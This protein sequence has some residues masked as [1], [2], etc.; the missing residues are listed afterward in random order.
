VS[1]GTL[2]DHAEDL[3]AFRDV[4]DT[5][6]LGIVH[7][8]HPFIAPMRAAKHGTLVGIASVAGFRGLP[9]PAAYSASKSATIT[10]LESLRVELRGSGVSVVTIAPGYVATP[11]TE[12]NPY[13]MPFLMRPE[14]RRGVDGARDR[15]PQ[16]LPRDAVADG[17]RSA[18]C[19][20]CCR[21][22]LRRRVREGAAQAAPPVNAATDWAG[23][24][25]ARAGADA[26]IASLVPSLTELL[27]A[28][29]L[30]DR[31]VARTGFCV[32]PHDAVRR[33]RKVGGTKD[34][35]LE[36]LREARPTHLIVNVDENRREAVDA[37][38][39]FVPDVIVTHP[40]APDDNRRLYALFG[41]IFDRE[42]HAA[43][44]A[45]RLDAALASLDR[46]VAARARER[47]LYL[48]WREPWMTVSRD[49]YVAATLR[50]R[51]ARHAARA[52]V[53]PLP[54]DRRRRS[55]VARRRS[56]PA[57]D[58]AVRVPRARPRVARARDRK[59]VDLVDGEWTSWYGVA[60]DRRARGARAL[61][62]A[63]G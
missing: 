11:M 54:G 32:H 41:A 30:G 17:A 19:C 46:A 20:A 6:V 49:T 60:R 50:T 62:Q 52:R 61:P 7:T 8:F 10:L 2:A 39:A 59:R 12:R 47:V 24:A 14:P 13:R 55:G 51:R 45:A 40:M 5:N 56:H 4:F 43:A 34:V 22:A 44:L 26:R 33:V 37:A 3:S 28:L 35:D 53:A 1:R 9:G 42:A 21:V 23:V 18:A 29:D 57:L 25:H 31:V 58:R 48:I 63:S 38:R 16:A 15:A 36:R 27:F